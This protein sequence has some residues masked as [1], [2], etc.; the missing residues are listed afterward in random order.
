MPFR[1]GCRLFSVA[2]KLSCRQTKRGPAAS[3]PPGL[4]ARTT[5][6]SSSLSLIDLCRPAAVGIDEVRDRLHGRKAMSAGSRQPAWAGWTSQPERSRFLGV[7][8]RIGPESPR[9]SHAERVLAHRASWA[10]RRRA[11]KPPG[12]WTADVSVAKC[13]PSFPGR[14]SLGVSQAKSSTMDLVTVSSGLAPTA[15]I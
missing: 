8:G 5:V 3:C 14:S 12:C 10:G 1:S 2:A 13:F 6:A 4:P 15:I 9:A 11:R 7:Q